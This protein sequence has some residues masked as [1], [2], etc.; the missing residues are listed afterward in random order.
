MAEFFAEQAAWLAEVVTTPACQNAKRRIVLA[1]T[2]PFEFNNSYMARNLYNMVGKLFYGENPPC[3]IDLWIAGHIHTYSRANRGESVIRAV[4]PWK[5]YADNK[6][7][8]TFVTT[9]GPKN[10]SIQPD[11]S[12]LEINVGE[13]TIGVTAFDE[14]GVML[15]KFVVK[16]SGEVENI[17]LN[18]SM[19]LFPIKNLNEQMRN[20]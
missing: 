13:N 18:K 7:A 2:T 17:F 20:F 8:V 6:S 11:L 3:K 12:F 10:K 14:N 16:Q 15:D 9:D 1:H 4:K 19:K 5:K